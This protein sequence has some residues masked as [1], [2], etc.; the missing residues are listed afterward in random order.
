MDAPPSLRLE[1]VRHFCQKPPSQRGPCSFSPA[2][3][4]KL[5]L[6]ALR[7]ARGSARRLA[8]RSSRRVRTKRLRGPHQGL[9]K[10]NEHLVV[11]AAYHKCELGLHAVQLISGSHNIAGSRG[12]LAPI[13]E[14]SRPDRVP[15]RLPRRDIDVVV[16]AGDRTDPRSR[17]PSLR[18][19][20]TRCR[21]PAAKCPESRS[22]QVAAE[23]AV[24]L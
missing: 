19:A 18:I 17:P 4:T 21:A 23:L 20:S 2:L 3:P 7:S 1:D 11:G 10:G 13:A 5:C 8:P 9:I 6:P 15:I 16:V 24:C 14:Q 12:V 22:P